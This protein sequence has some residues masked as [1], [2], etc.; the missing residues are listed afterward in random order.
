MYLE[1]LR[2]K[3]EKSSVINLPEKQASPMNYN[4]NEALY[5]QSDVFCL[6][7]GNRRDSESVSLLTLFAFIAC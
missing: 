1:S 6:G 3:F 4:F 2:F 5:L 7:T